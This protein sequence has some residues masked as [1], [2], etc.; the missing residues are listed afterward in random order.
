[1]FCGGLELPFFIIFMDKNKIIDLVNQSLSDNPSL[2]LVS[3][4]INPENHISIVID[5]DKGASLNECIKVSRY[6][7]GV[8]DVDDL[9]YSIDVATPDIAKPLQLNRQYIKN[10]GRTLKVTTTTEEIEAN[11]KF[12]NEDG[13]V[14]VKEERVPKTIGKGKMTVEREIVLPFEE[15]VQA[16]VLIV[17]N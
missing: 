4:E 14:L 11:L 16:K 10:I 5:G 1:M 8:L 6:V 15:I 13:I 9:E 7:E 17:F 12:V 2:F 3:L